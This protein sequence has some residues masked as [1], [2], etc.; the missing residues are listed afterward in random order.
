M[1]F[2]PRPCA[3]VLRDFTG[4]DFTEAVVPP[5]D[6]PVLRVLPG[7]QPTPTVSTFTPLPQTLRALS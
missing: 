7:L 3:L 6:L 2:A 4:L 5:T 1:S